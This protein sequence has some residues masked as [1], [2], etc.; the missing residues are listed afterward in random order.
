ME[1][2]EKKVNTEP[3]QKKLSYDDLNNVCHQLS[4]QVRTLYRR[5]QE[6]NLENSFKRL[7]YLF[8]VIENAPVFMESEEFYDNCVKEIIAAMTIKEEPSSKEDN[9]E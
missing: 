5:L 6:V 1:E 2:K 4:E 7:D 3:A 8:K 9:K